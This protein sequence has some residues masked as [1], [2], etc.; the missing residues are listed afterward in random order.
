MCREITCYCIFKDYRRG[1]I[2]VQ[3]LYK[4]GFSLG[5]NYAWYA[6]FTRKHAVVVHADIWKYNS[7]E[8]LAQI[9]FI[10]TA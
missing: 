9:K 1:L 3:L 8:M 6:H 5:K 2:E 4:G 7:Q 10:L